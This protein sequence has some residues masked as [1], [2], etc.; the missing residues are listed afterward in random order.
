MLEMRILIAEVLMF[1]YSISDIKTHKIDIRFIV[2]AWIMI[3]FTGNEFCITALIP[4]CI[5]IAI[6]LVFPLHIGLG[7]G[8]LF[9]FFGMICRLEG[10]ISILLI[11]FFMTAV[12]AAFIMIRHNIS[13]MSED[14]N[15]TIPLVPFIFASFNIVL[16]LGYDRG[17][18]I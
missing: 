6:A 12:Y 3:F 10:V 16:L 8:I 1:I 17:L 9:A 5:L 4:G 14:K 11:S 7:D 15:A 18:F 13:G 2:I